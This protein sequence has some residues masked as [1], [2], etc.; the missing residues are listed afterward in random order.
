MITAEEREQLKAEIL[1]ELNQTLKG[2]LTTEATSSVMAE[3][4][5]KWFGHD[6]KMDEIFDTY[7]AW[8]IW[9]HVRKITCL[10][11]GENYVRRLS[12]K[13]EVA[14][15]VAECICQTIYNARKWSLDPNEKVD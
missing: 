15:S 2:V 6:G 1:A 5:N 12:G 14:N 7:V 9:E 4:R 11:C 8:K 13:E 3:A 10:V